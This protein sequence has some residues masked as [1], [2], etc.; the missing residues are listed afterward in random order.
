METNIYAGWKERVLY[1]WEKVVGL[2]SY[3]II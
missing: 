1:P 3:G 2:E